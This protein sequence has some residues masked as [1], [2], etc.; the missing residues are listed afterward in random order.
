MS[1]DDKVIDILGDEM[2]EAGRKNFGEEK[3]LDGVVYSE[4]VKHIDIS[5]ECDVTRENISEIELEGF[6]ID[7]ITDSSLR[8]SHFAVVIKEK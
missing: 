2:V 3:E 8:N 4:E 1:K 6:V 7:K 5:K